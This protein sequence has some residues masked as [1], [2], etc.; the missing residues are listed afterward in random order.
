MI[1]ISSIIPIGLSD[2][3][4]IDSIAHEFLRRTKLYYNP[5]SYLADSIAASNLQ[6]D[7]AILYGPLSA[8]ENT[9]LTYLHEHY[10]AIITNNP[11][12]LLNHVSAI[13]NN[14][15]GQITGVGFRRRFQ[16][17]SFGVAVYKLFGY[18]QHFRSQ[19]TK[20]VWLARQ[21]N[22]KTCPYCNAQY[23][24]IVPRGNNFRAKF[25]FD[26]FFSKKRFPYLSLSLYNLIPSCAPCN[27]SKKDTSTNL[28]EFYHPYHNNLAYRSYFRAS[29]PIDLRKLTIGNVKKLD[30]NIRFVARYPE[31]DNLISTHTDLYDIEGTY[32]R[33]YDI[34]Q[35]LMVK[36]V[37]NNSSFKSDI[38][39]IRGLFDG[40]ESLYRR[41]LLGN[42]GITEEITE[43]PLSKM[44]QD[45]AKQFEII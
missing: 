32:S 12:T 13:D 15:F 4:S 27:L 11:A 23:T 7:G 2:K 3:V 9:V 31:F 6:A 38:M 36:A 30:I 17:S 14:L 22:I 21:L 5:Y 45:I 18:E 33:H 41:Y 43:R 39:E 28:T 25:Q 40:D 19:G 1:K 34:V 24:L 29:F 37:M 8:A 44:T 10:D 16:M 26:H 35:D 42:Y 20:G